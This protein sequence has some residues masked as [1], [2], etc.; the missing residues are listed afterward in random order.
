MILP[1]IDIISPTK[2]GDKL[3]VELA[4][5]HYHAGTCNSVVKDM[6]GE[7]HAF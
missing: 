5:S 4:T 1:H 2:A 6:V 7:W 3:S